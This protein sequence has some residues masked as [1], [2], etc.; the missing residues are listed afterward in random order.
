MKTKD[1]KNIFILVLFLLS[2]SLAFFF[3]KFSPQK[4]Q[5]LAQ[6][7]FFP[8]KPMVLYIA[9][10][11]DFDESDLEKLSDLYDNGMNSLILG[12]WWSITKLNNTISRIKNNEILSRYR[13]IYT[14]GGP[15]YDSWHSCA[16]N[17]DCN[18]NTYVPT[19]YLNQYVNIIKN[20]PD[21]FVGYYTFDEPGLQKI[22]KIYQENVYSYIRTIDPEAVSRPIII[23]NTMWSLTDQDIEKYL[24]PNAQDVIFIDQ[25]T[26]DLNQQKQWFQLWKNH[27]LLSKPFVVVLPAYK[28]QSGC[29]ELNLIENVNTYKSAASSVSA[30]SKLQGFAY[31]AYWP[32]YTRPKP[33]FKE[34]VDNCG[35]I[36]DSVIKSLKYLGGSKNN[37]FSASMNDLMAWYRFYRS[38]SDDSSADFDCNGKVDISDLIK[39][40]RVYRR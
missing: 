39:W 8:K 12:G 31:F 9:N 34:G 37:Q 38:G 14:M 27:N 3:S 35:L 11:S 4:K 17:P 25:Y 1:E 24:S 16:N 20:N 15:L 22:P 6:S 30:L 28:P 21:I 19:A 18:I 13:Y 29:S 33:D 5:A 23:A 2:L 26:N 40:Y 7:C 36:F 32:D 10:F